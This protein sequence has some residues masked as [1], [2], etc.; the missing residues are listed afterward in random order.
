MSSSGG[1]FH[2]RMKEFCSEM[3]N[4]NVACDTENCQITLFDLVENVFVCTL[5][6]ALKS[7]FMGLSLE[8]C[9]I[10]RIVV[11]YNRCV[12]LGEKTENRNESFFVYFNQPNNEDSWLFVDIN[13][14]YSCMKVDVVGLEEVLFSN[15]PP[16]T[17]TLLSEEL[18]KYMVHP[19][20]EYL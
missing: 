15:T 1:V 3:Y 20:N 6:S 18:Q 16:K 5:R 17:Y 10:T 9:S 19:T 12:N 14:I 13:K 4:C 7:D 11:D 8:G 2:C